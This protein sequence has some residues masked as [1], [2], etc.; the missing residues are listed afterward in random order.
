MNRL[1]GSGASNLDSLGVGS[2]EQLLHFCF[3][4]ISARFLFLVLNVFCR[5][6]INSILKDIKV[7]FSMF[8]YFTSILCLNDLEFMILHQMN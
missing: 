1:R 8:S 6:C 7:E 4:S 5:E 2:E 3:S